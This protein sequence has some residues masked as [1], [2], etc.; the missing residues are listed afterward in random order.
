MAAYLV[1]LVKLLAKE[2]F[3][4]RVGFV[5]PGPPGIPATGCA[6]ALAKVILRALLGVAR[7]A[8]CLLDFLEFFL[9]LLLFQGRLAVLLSVGMKFHRE[10]PVGRSDLFEAVLKSP[11]CSGHRSI[12]CSLC[13]NF[14]AGKRTAGKNG[15]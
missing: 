5:R 8:V 15:S 14:L 2:V 6:I 13:D 12:V 10:P 9:G 1:A 4:I 7:D 3:E 11:G